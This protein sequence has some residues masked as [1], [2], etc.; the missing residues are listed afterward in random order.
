VIGGG[1]L[2]GGEGTIAGTLIGAL[3]IGVLFAGCVQMGWPNWIQTVVT[4]L[5]IAVAVLMDRLR[6]QQQIR[7]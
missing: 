2:S 7:I 1:S 3:L 4:G 5:I 6:Q